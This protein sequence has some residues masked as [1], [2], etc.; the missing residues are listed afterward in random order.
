MKLLA[1]AS[2]RLHATAGLRMNDGEMSLAIGPHHSFGPPDSPNE[3]VNM[4]QTTSRHFCSSTRCLRASTIRCACGSNSSAGAPN[5]LNE[6][7][8]TDR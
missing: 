8:R 6:R 7:G 5:A 1:T 3:S 2:Q 4:F